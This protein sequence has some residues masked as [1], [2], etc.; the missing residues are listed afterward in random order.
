MKILPYLLFASLL[1]VIYIILFILPNHVAGFALIPEKVFQGEF[2]RFF[3]YPFD[4]LDSSHLI[5]NLIGLMI[6]TI[7]LIELKTKFSDFSSVYLLAGFLAVLP[8]WFLIQFTALGAS[9]A[10]YSAF[11]LIALE[12]KKY[13]IKEWHILSLI[14]LTI[15]TE[16]ILSGT[17]TAMLSSLSHF[18]GLVFGIFAFVF[19]KK[20]HSGLDKK[21][22]HCLRKI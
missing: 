3:T 12:A 18:S 11:G 5:K 2:W 17:N 9:V 22:I 21:K 6:I 1:S 16:A 15:F 7:G 13:E 10:I 14:A 8:L 19:A 20:I 4:H